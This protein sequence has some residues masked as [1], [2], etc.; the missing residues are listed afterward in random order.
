MFASNQRMSVSGTQKLIFS[1]S[2]G[3]CFLFSTYFARRF[4]FVLSLFFCTAIFLFCLFR[5]RFCRHTFFPLK[6]FVKSII[7]LV[8][9]ML[10][11]TKYVHEHLLFHTNAVFLIL[12]IALTALPVSLGSFEERGRLA[13]F[14]APVLL[15]TLL[16]SF[17]VLFASLD[18]SDLC[19]E[20]PKLFHTTYLIS[21]KNILKAACII[22]FTG[23]ILIPGTPKLSA[24][25]FAYCALLL[26]LLSILTIFMTCITN[27]RQPVF[28]VIISL[29]F[30][31]AARM[32]HCILPGK[33]LLF[34]I[35][36]SLLCI[37]LLIL[38]STLKASHY[39]TFLSSFH[40]HTLYSPED[41]WFD[42][43]EPEDRSFVLSVFIAP[44]EDAPAYTCQIMD[45]REGDISFHYVSFSDFS[46]YEAFGNPA[47]DFSFLKGILTDDSKDSSL[48]LHQLIKTYD[49]S[50]EVPIF[51]KKEI[52]RA[53]AYFSENLK[54]IN[55]GDC[56]GNLANASSPETI[57]KS[58]TK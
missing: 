14:L 22:F 51:S 36:A 8:F 32:H 16:F 23:W 40:F 49:I 15:I 54:H 56:L 10:L 57:S 4:G 38:P 43:K 58:S 19:D 50:P 34:P 41:V 27:L 2:I 45:F 18:F 39:L 26:Y 29:F 17:F 31:I 44:T 25:P 53:Y 5:Q 1:E 30:Y 47:L 28:P 48:L 37:L 11:L 35:L 9:S 13:V 52:P 3:L 7:F 21:F 6:Q 55:L 46:T 20:F 24:R 12:I 33:K 42:G